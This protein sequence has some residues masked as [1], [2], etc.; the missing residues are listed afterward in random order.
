MFISQISTLNNR[1]IVYSTGTRRYIAFIDSDG[2]I[3]WDNKFWE[4]MYK[5]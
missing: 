4:P 3:V 5:L 1:F 2:I